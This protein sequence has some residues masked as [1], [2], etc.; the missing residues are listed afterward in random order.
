MSATSKTTALWRGFGSIVFAILGSTFL[1]GTLVHPIDLPALVEGC[2]LIVVGRVTSISE[3]QARRA[4]QPAASAPVEIL[5]GT[6]AI[7]ALLKGELEGR[8]VLFEFLKSGAPGAIRPVPQGQYGIFF[9]RGKGTSY[10]LADPLYPFLPAVPN[11]HFVSGPSLDQVVAKLGEILA[12]A[13]STDEELASALDALGSTPGT[14]ATETLRHALKA[15]SG[16]RQLRIAS[17]L[18]SRNDMTG[19]DI[20]ETNL[21][22]PGQLPDELH[23]V[24]AGS[25]AGLNDPK[26]IPALQ[27]LL[28]TNDQQIAR[29]AV[30]ALRQTHSAD[31]LEPLS[32]LLTNSDA[33]VRYHAVVGLGEITGQDEWTPAFDEFRQNEAKY[34]SHWRDWAAT[35][36]P[37]GTPH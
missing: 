34:L 36:L 26:A 22:Q 6:L 21:R 16:Q 7:D 30:V 14:F 15:T 2:D 11:G 37:P 10:A 19:L 25:L 29:W 33:W 24:L 35:N 20:V 5:E 17:R 9:L 8:I 3:T 23:A 31:A 13:N 32:Q 27:R 1:S 4:S 18:V 12:E 28:K